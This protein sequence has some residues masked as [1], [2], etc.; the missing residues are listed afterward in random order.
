MDKIAEYGIASHWSYKEHKD[1][2]K[3]HLKDAM[4]QKKL[5]IFRNIIELNEEANNS[6]EFIS[7]VKKDIF[8]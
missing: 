5:Q 6:E 1:G 4:E 3:N 8:N 2:E 7:S